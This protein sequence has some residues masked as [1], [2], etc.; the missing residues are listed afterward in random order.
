MTLKNNIVKVL[1]ESETPLDTAEIAEHLNANKDSI[2]TLCLQLKKEGIVV[3]VGKQPYH[4]IIKESLRVE[5]SVSE[6]FSRIAQIKSQIT[7]IKKQEIQTDQEQKDKIAGFIA[8]QEESVHIEKIVEN[9]PDIHVIKVSQLLDELKNDG[10]IKSFEE[11]YAICTDED[12]EEK[13][14]DQKVPEKK[15]V[16]ERI[17]DLLLVT[18]PLT[19]HDI[20]FKLGLPR[21]MSYYTCSI[22]KKKGQIV[23]V[24]PKPWHYTLPEKVNEFTSFGIS[25]KSKPKEKKTEKNQNIRYPY[26]I[27]QILKFLSKTPNSTLAEIAKGLDRPRQRISEV[28]YLMEKRRMIKHIGDGKPRRYILEIKKPE[29]NT[30]KKEIISMKKRKREKILGNYMIAYVTEGSDKPEFLHNFKDTADF[31]NQ[32]S[33][34]QDRKNVI[35]LTAFRV[36]KLSKKIIYVPEIS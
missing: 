22:M 36:M 29:I 24:G 33:S 19:V 27:D 17:I 1:V 13:E 34:L 20:R 32:F 5:G 28:L 12:I 16:S 2:A 31:I 3:S 14:P 23:A 8:E 11:G 15:K 35:E 25:E 6:T 26:R 30:Q 9:F 4:Y 7:A 21:P 18:E 10:I